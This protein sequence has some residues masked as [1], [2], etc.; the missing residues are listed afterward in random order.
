MNFLNNRED[1]SEMASPARTQV[2]GVD[3]RIMTTQNERAGVITSRFANVLSSQYELFDVQTDNLT[4]LKASETSKPL[5][6]DLP[7]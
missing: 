3:E 7:F 6:V 5:A 2:V 1:V 4:S